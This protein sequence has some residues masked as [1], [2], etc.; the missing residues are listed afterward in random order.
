ME[1]EAA[2][3]PA[4]HV[5]DILVVDDTP[6]NLRLL[7]RLLS[8]AGFHVRPAA[9]GETAI[10]AAAARPPDLVLLDVDMPGMDGYEVCRALKQDPALADVPVVFLSA[11]GETSDK[12]EAFAAGGVDYVTKPFHLEELRAR[13]ATH[14]E[15]RQLRRELEQRNRDLAESNQRLREVEQ[16]RHDLVHMV[17]HD[18]RSPLMGVSGYLELLELEQESLD[19][20][21]RDF[22]ARALESARALVR[23]L[24]AMLDADR[25]ESNRVPLQLGAHDLDGLLERAASTFGPMGAR[26]IVLHPRGDGS[27]RVRCDAEIVL[28]VAANLIA[29]ALAHSEECESV[30]VGILDGSAGRLRIE[31]RDRGPGVP[32]EIR[33]RLFDKYVSSGA[34]RGRM[35]SM[36]LGLAFCKLAIDAHQGTIG[37]D[38]SAEAGSRF[39]FELPREGPAPAPRP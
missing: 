4:P 10:A 37:F 7:E 28:R 25:L 36:G 27:A 39:W 15:L 12:L 33:E 18:M 9:S 30:D 26:R 19:E 32:S 38:S 6:A 23:Q 2:A 17:A 11:L 14:L 22:V 13:I 24:D 3:A 29:N 35:R 31:V 8:G 16:L 1:P 34:P 5:A 21:Q 20:T